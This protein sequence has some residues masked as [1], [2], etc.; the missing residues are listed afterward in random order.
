[1]VSPKGGEAPV[2][3]HSV[4]AFRDESSVS[5]LNTKSKLWKETLKLTDIVP[6]AGEFDAIFYVGGHGRMNPSPFLMIY[7]NERLINCRYN[8]NSNV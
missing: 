4:E 5:F 6:R 3:P 1:V 7:A 2:D 8:S